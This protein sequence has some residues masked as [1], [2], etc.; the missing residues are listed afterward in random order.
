M[1]TKAKAKQ[2]ADV[3]DTEEPE[4]MELKARYHSEGC[5]MDPDDLEWS[6]KF[7]KAGRHAGHNIE[8]IRCCR[9]G[10]Q[11]ERRTD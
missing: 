3:K 1:T 5:P 9:C 8:I 11:T 2:K 6:E 7:A 4:V 10:G